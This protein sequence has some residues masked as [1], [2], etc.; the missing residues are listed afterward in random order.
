MIVV[1]AVVFM[2]MV[3]MM[4][5]VMVTVALKVK[6]TVTSIV[7]SSHDTSSSGLN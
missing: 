5:W 1:A 7:L 4:V 6:P 3:I 2:G